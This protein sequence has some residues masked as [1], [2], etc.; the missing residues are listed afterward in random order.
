MAST[1]RP[2]LLLII[3]CALI[4]AQIFV[5]TSLKHEVNEQILAAQHAVNTQTLL[6]SALVKILAEKG[7]ITREDL[8][9]EASAISQQ[10]MQADPAAEPPFDTSGLVPSE[11]NPVDR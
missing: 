3:V 10:V 4:I 2:R 5:I 7:V 1:Y 11:V 8:L 6:Q 9:R